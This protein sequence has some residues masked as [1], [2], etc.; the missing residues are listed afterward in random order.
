M[1]P[2]FNLTSKLL[3][4]S[5]QARFKAGSGLP[6]A[7]LIEINQTQAAPGLGILRGMLQHVLVFDFRLIELA[8]G[9]I[10]IR[11]FLVVGSL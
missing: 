11:A 8:G 10:L 2:N 9:V 4:S 5:C 3:V 1:V 6:D 7:T